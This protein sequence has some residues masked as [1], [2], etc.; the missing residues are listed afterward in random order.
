ML[1]CYILILAHVVLLQSAKLIFSELNQAEIYF[2]GET[3]R[4]QVGYCFQIYQKNKNK[5]FWSTMLFLLKEKIPSICFL[6]Y[7]PHTPYLTPYLLERKLLDLYQTFRI[8]FFS[9]GYFLEL[10]FSFSF[11]FFPL[12]WGEG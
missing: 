7:Y 12:A 4:L 9:K 8:L 10:S 3:N 2:K 5:K 11:S 1:A 6:Y